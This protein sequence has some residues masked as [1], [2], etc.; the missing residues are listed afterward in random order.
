MEPHT[1]KAQVP[2]PSSEFALRLLLALCEVGVRDVV[3]SPGSRSQALSLAAAELEAA[4][5]L[6]LHVRIDERSAAFLA[7]GLTKASG[8]PTPVIVTS[9]SAVGNLLPAV[10]EAHRSFQPLVILSADRPASVRCR[11]ASQTTHQVG[12]FS[13][14]TRYACD[15]STPDL[16]TLTCTE[17][18]WQPPAGLELSEA[19]SALL[20][21]SEATTAHTFSSL[22]TLAGHLAAALAS[23]GPSHLNL[24]FRE[25]LSGPHTPLAEL[26]A[27]SKR[28]NT[29]ARVDAS[30]ASAEAKRQALNPQRC[31]QP[32]NPENP[33]SAVQLEPAHTLVIAGF[34]AEHYAAPGTLPAGP[35][36]PALPIPSGVDVLAEVTSSWRA[37][38]TLGANYRSLLRVGLP[39]I[40]SLVIVGMPNLSREVAALCARPDLAVYTLAHPGEETFLPEGATAISYVSWAQS[41]QQ[42]GAHVVGNS[43]GQIEAAA[44]NANVTLTRETLI[45]TLFDYCT[46]HRAPIYLAASHLVRLADALIDTAAI[47][48]YSHRGLAGIDGTIAL[49]TGCALGSRHTDLPTLGRDVTGGQ[50]PLSATEP[51]RLLIGDLAFLHD[52]GSLARAE[53]E[54]LPPVQIIVAN[55]HG[56]H[57]FSTLEVAQADPAA[58][59]RVVA[60]PMNVDLAPL[61][62]AYGWPYTRVAT[63][64]EL[65]RALATNRAMVIEAT[66]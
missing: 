3:V 10:M 42:A 43:S 29:P 11:G 59:Q 4:G 56:G 18:A 28:G 64:A 30:A 5:L 55:D 66:F 41:S 52:A 33:N 6:R 36:A 21:C 1:G 47:P 53:G 15:V 13:R 58:Y 27:V 22:A 20:H 31:A 2:C 39:H 14:F 7:L 34:A 24:Q 17:Y 25:P 38:H 44:L 61:A 57:I 51:L 23:N 45:S 40:T 26:V 9:G 35:H 19:E 62:T 54:E 37:D 48:V 63:P 46:Q 8:R 65:Q 60:T 50:P 12:I 32:A 16:D 49:A